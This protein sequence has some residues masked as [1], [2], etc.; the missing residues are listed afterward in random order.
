MKS[1]TMFEGRALV[2]ALD[3]QGRGANIYHILRKDYMSLFTYFIK[4]KGE[5]VFDLVKNSI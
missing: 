5:K 2:H 1:I 4:G 3:H